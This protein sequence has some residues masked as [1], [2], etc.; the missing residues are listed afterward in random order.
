MWS[1]SVNFN[2]S[3]NEQSAPQRRHMNSVSMTRYYYY[4]MPGDSALRLVH[5]DHMTSQQFL[6]FSRRRTSLAFNG[7]TRLRCAVSRWNSKALVY[8]VIKQMM[9]GTSGNAQPVSLGLRPRETDCVITWHRVTLCSDWFIQRATIFA[10]AQ[11]PNRS[12]F[13][14]D[15]QGYDVRYL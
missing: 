1:I 10:V 8:H 6:L 3:L 12:G 9:T 15:T 13:Q 2:N 11:P 7:Y 4:M 14:T 5:F